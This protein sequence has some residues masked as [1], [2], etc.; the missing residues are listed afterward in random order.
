MDEG[1]QDFPLGGG[2][3]LYDLLSMNEKYADDRCA[4]REDWLLL[5]AFREAGQKFRVFDNDSTDVIVP[6]GEGKAIVEALRSGRAMRDVEY[7]AELVEKAKPYTVALYDY[8]I[9]ELRPEMVCGCVYVLDACNYDEQL[10]VVP[11][12]KEFGFW[13]V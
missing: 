7:R 6:Y 9:K 8:Q 13:E 1:A 4:E 5:Q 11:G 10:G 3:S 2:R 12:R